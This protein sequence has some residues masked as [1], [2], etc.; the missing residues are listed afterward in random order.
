MCRSGIQDDRWR[1]RCLSLRCCAI[2]RLRQTARPLRRRCLSLRCCAK[3][4][5]VVRRALQTRLSL[6]WRPMCRSGI[7]ADRWRQ[8][9]RPFRCSPIRRLRQTVR[10]LRQRCRPF[11]CCAMRHQVCRRSRWTCLCFRWRPMCRLS[12]SGDHQSEIDLWPR[13]HSFS[14][15]PFYIRGGVNGG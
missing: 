9:C 10:P 11:R 3:R 8:R 13:K 7:Q 4:R 15:Y 5:R 2:R 14:L 6:R 1:Q 12:V